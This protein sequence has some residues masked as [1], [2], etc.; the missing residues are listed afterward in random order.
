LLEW[1]PQAKTSSEDDAQS[2]TNTES[3]KAIKLIVEPDEEVEVVEDINTDDEWV[4]LVGNQ[5]QPSGSRPSFNLNRN[6]RDRSHKSQPVIKDPNSNEPSRVRRASATSNPINNGEDD[7]FDRWRRRRA[8]FANWRAPVRFEEDEDAPE[9][10]RDVFRFPSPVQIPNDS[11][12]ENGESDEGEALSEPSEVNRP[13]RDRPIVLRNIPRRARSEPDEEI[14]LS[15]RPYPISFPRSPFVLPEGFPKPQGPSRPAT[16]FREANYPAEAVRADYTA[17][18]TKTEKKVSNW[19]AQQCARPCDV[20]GDQIM[21]WE[22]TGSTKEQKKWALIY[23]SY[24]ERWNSAPNFE[25]KDIEPLNEPYSPF[26]EYPS[27]M[28]SLNLRN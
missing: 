24:L 14:Q 4:T 5:L 21:E 20:F 10:R 23:R 27:G 28:C 22:S 18:K 19:M 1:I 25:G 15:R 6:L 13:A 9:H 8:K 16:P 12:D 7:E 26:M 17:K 11:D 2:G 3:N